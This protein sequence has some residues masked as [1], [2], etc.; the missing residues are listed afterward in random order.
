MKASVLIGPKRSQVQE[1][2]PP[3]PGP[4]EVLVRVKAC[5]VCRSELTEWQAGRG[6]EGRKVLGHEP[7]G[8]VE[9]VGPGV[10]SLRAGERVTVFTGRAGRWTDYTSGAYSEYVVV[11]Q[12]NAVPL[13]EGLP[14][15]LALGEPLACLVSAYERTPIR[16]S[17]RVALIGCGFMGL[18]MLQL[19]RL[20]SPRELVAVD[21]NPAALELARRFGADR[22]CA[23]QEVPSVRY[24]KDGD[25]GFDVVV[26][27]T[28]APR[29]LDLA[30][31]IAAAHGT[32]SIVG[33]H[34]R[35]EV[36]VGLWNLK[37]LTVINAHEKRRAYFMDCM[38]S[39]VELV[40]KGKLDMRALVTHRY[41][42]GEI[43]GAFE[44]LLQKTPGHTKGVVVID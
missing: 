13:P 24:W 44:D 41:A 6:D 15:E 16:L 37:G 9:R 11:P 14:F 39:G 2:A 29:A 21:S 22:A 26:E 10:A 18:A 8:V 34:H 1:L 4:D 7:S 27:V 5:G 40:A 3:S 42:L 25:A 19:L 28:G 17:D 30:G 32:I 33:A 23:P 31:E 43:D 20:R 38:R 35:Q 36:D 12:E